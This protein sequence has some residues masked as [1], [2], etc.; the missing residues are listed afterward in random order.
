[1][2]SADALRMFEIEPLPVRRF[3]EPRFVIWGSRTARHC[4]QC[5]V[6]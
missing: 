2:S 5:A 4:G 6:V 1:L 3:G